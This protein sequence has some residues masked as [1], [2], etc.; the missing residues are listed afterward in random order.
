[1]GTPSDEF[2]SKLGS[3]AAMYVRSLPRQSGIPIEEIAPDANFLKDTE[4]V[5]SHLTAEYA[6][7]LLSKMLVIDPDYRFS[8]EESLNHPYVK[9]WFRDDEVNAPQSENR[10]NEE[11]DSSDKQL[12][13][14][15]GN[16]E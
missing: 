3:S 12:N 16:K 1:M 11:I 9:L 2:I 7:D 5:R 8:V 15:K 4:N 6:R 14:W 13:E 10:Y